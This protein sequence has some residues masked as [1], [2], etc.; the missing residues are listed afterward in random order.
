V[1]HDHAG[2]MIRVPKADGSGGYF[3]VQYD[4][5]GRISGIYEDTNQDG[6]LDL[7]GENPD[8]PVAHNRYDPTGRRIVK[9]T[10]DS[11]EVLEARHFYYNSRWQ[12]LEERVE[13][14][15][16]G[17]TV[18]VPERQM[19]WSPRY[20]DALILRDRDA[21]A[22]PQTGELGKSASGLEERVFYLADA[23]YNV[24]ALVDTNGNVLERYAYDPYGKVTVLD[25]DFAELAQQQSAY[26]NTTL[27][28]G[29]E[30]D[31]ETG[32]YYYRARYYHPHLG[33]F[34][35]RDPLLYSAGDANL[36]RY[37]GNRPLAGGDPLGL[38]TIDPTTGEIIGRQAGG[39]HFE[40][41]H[42]FP[43]QFRTQ[44]EEKCAEF[45]FRIDAF[46][47]LLYAGNLYVVG[48]SRP[49]LNYRGSE[50]WYVHHGRSQSG[51]MDWNPF[52]S[53]TLKQ[54]ATCCDFLLT[55]AQEREAVLQELK[56]LRRV[57]HWKFPAQSGT[58]LDQM[59]YS[60]FT[61]SSNTSLQQALDYLDGLQTMALFQEIQRYCRCRKDGLPTGSKPDVVEWL[62]SGARERKRIDDWWE[63]GRIEPTYDEVK[64][65]LL[66][67]GPL[68]W[69]LNRAAGAGSLGTGASAAAAAGAADDAARLIPLEEALRKA[70]EPAA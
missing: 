1:D 13:R 5:W 47:T 33:R 10:F 64:V 51:K 11:G 66:F 17:Q 46:T 19:V 69:M 48:G 7:E 49:L 14:E 40:R 65:F 43:Q 61:R 16:E 8:Q 44:I 2:N 23:N 37:V 41:H 54:S 35:T 42:W 32:L 3:L 53:Q 59:Q 22:N 12:C 67:S 52:V 56:N 26:S 70:L 45:S 25:P 6:R 18:L 29:R 38:V 24:T 27:Y 68:R 57:T 31:L 55:V 50:H 15:V 62:M 36:Y 28:T 9:E 21:D 34:L 63:D 58:W 39:L 4:A 30:L 60:V 20:I